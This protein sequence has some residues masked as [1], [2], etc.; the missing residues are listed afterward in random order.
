MPQPWLVLARLLVTVVPIE[1]TLSPSPPLPCTELPAIVFDTEEVST[2]IPPVE[3]PSST[4]PN[5]VFPAEPTTSM[6]S[7]RLDCMALNS[8]TLPAPP[9]SSTPVELL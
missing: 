4:L 3:L 6:P 5:T 9:D 1:L 8:T 7:P 2:Q